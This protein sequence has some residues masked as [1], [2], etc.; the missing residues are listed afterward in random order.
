M[1]PCD[2]RQH[3]Q[4]NYVGLPNGLSTG[5]GSA[6]LSSM[7]ILGGDFGRMQA[8]NGHYPL[9]NGSFANPAKTSGFESAFAGDCQSKTIDRGST[10]LPHG[11][12][13]CSVSHFWPEGDAM[14]CEAVFQPLPKESK[15]ETRVRSVHRIALRSKKV[16]SVT[17]TPLHS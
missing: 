6:G 16:A 13:A 9:T 4:G 10:V 1:S 12:V 11:F 5:M 7:D 2:K 3:M 17:P 8:S 14:D 15:Q